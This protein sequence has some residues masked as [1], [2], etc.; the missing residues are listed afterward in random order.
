TATIIQMHSHDSVTTHAAHEPSLLAIV[1]ATVVVIRHAVGE[2]EP[3]TN[4]RPIEPTSQIDPFTAIARPW[5]AAKRNRNLSG[6]KCLFKFSQ[7]FAHGIIQSVS[8]I[9]PGTVDATSARR[10]HAACARA[11][12]AFINSKRTITPVATGSSTLATT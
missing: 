10:D 4:H 2:V 3:C 5:L 6:R 11:L 9:R 7:M 1:R 12:R 8:S